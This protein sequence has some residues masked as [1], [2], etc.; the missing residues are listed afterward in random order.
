MLAREI[1][2]RKR[3]GH[4]LERAHIDAF[5]RGLVDRS[6]SD[7]QAA[8]MAMAFF[9][10]DMSHEETMALTEAMTRS[11]TV[12]D[13]H[14]AFPGPIVDKHSSGGLGHNVSVVLAP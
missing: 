13:W 1:I 12:L 4:P 2:R 7:A 10:E 14:S 5:V 6:W 9:L 3:D 8:A 11:G